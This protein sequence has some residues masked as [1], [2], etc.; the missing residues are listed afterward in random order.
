MD[1]WTLFHKHFK[2]G[3]DVCLIDDNDFVTIGK[4]VAFNDDGCWIQEGRNTAPWF[5]WWWDIRFMSHDGFP[6][7]KLLGADG[8]SS[9][10][11]SV[12]TVNILHELRTSF[13]PHGRR[14]GRRKPIDGVQCER[15]ERTVPRGT[16]EPVQYYN[17]ISNYP[18]TPKEV[19]RECQVCRSDGHDTVR[20][21]GCVMGDPFLVEGVS[22]TMHNPGNSGPRFWDT[23]FEESLE[24]V[25]PDGAAAIL[26]DLGTVYYFEAA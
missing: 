11:Q 10:E 12:D 25:A 18:K 16:L 1:V 20:R 4:L 7:K 21:F 19:L 6:V 9:I 26:S 5:Y 24:L 14:K 23:Y 13:E 17:K 2:K 15:C 22:A 8:S 3:H